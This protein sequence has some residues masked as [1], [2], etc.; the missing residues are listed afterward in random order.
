MKLLKPLIIACLLLLPLL[1]FAADSEYGYPIADPYAATILGTPVE[2]MP[3]FPAG[4]RIRQLV[5][6]VIP[7]REKPPVFFTTMGFAAV[8]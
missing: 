5:L 4:I 7:E 1:S 3:Q 2:L 6:T 8:L